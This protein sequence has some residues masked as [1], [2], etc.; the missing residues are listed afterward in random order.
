MMKDFKYADE[1]VNYM[2]DFWEELIEEGM[3]KGREEGIEKGR[4]EGMAKGREE[5][6]REAEEAAKA[7]IAEAEAA[8]AEAEAKAD[9][10][11]EAVRAES[12][13]N[14]MKKVLRMIRD[15]LKVDKIMEYSDLPKEEIEE[16]IALTSH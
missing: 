13:S 7:R 8:R 12:K 2:C 16:L 1:G 11:V 9:D 4:E 6:R 5:G 10:R 15:G 3:E 14:A